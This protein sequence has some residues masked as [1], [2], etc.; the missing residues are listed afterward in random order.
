MLD[1]RGSDIWSA[2][3]DPGR[4]LFLAAV[5]FQLVLPSLPIYDLYPF[6]FDVCPYHHS[7]HIFL[8]PSP[9]L[10]SFW[11]LRVAINP[12]KGFCLCSS[13]FCFQTGLHFYPEHLTIW[14]ES[15]RVTGGASSLFCTAVSFTNTVVLYPMMSCFLATRKFQ[16]SPLLS[17][18]IKVATWAFF[19][20]DGVCIVL[21]TQ[22]TALKGRGSSSQQDT[23]VSAQHITADEC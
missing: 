10:P 5:L 13:F 15:T 8:H 20:E 6:S 12:F 11:S 14:R 2:V 7:S 19:N 3:L 23:V 17:S 1:S 22:K 4:K 18:G 9:V 16:G 21:R